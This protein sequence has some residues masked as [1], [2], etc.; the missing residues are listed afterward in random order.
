MRTIKFRAWD[1]NGDNPQEKSLKGVMICHEYLM[2]HPKTLIK[3]IKGDYILIQF[4]G[5]LDSQG[6]EIYEGDIIEIDGGSDKVNGEVIFEEGC[7]CFKAP[8]IKEGNSYPELKYYT[9]FAGL[10]DDKRFKDCILTKIIG[11][12]YEHNELLKQ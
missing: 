8:W 12:I 9:V 10:N 5:L 2:N 4:T 7:F 11:N 6:K 3:A 1:K